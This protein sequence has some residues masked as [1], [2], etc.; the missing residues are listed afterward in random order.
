[1]L[2]VYVAGAYSDEDVLGVLKNIGRGQDYA[3]ELFHLGFAPFV[4]WFDKEFVINKW[5]MDY[6]VPMFYEYSMEWLRASDAVFVVP[7]HPG[8]KDW[9]DSFGVKKEVEEAE[10][11]GIPVFYSVKD[12]TRWKLDKQQGE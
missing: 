3:A 6:S 7:N 4:P 8:M 12:I 2:R 1:M 10:R 5:W 11:F 9:E